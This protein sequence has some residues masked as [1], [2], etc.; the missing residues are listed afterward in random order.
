MNSYVV[1]RDTETSGI[2][3]PPKIAVGTHNIAQKLRV[4]GENYVLMEKRLGCYFQVWS[5]YYQV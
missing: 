1:T 5:P 3:T 4:N 2:S